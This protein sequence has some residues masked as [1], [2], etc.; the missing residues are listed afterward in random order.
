MAEKLIE[1]R[2]RFRGYQPVKT[3]ESSE[4]EDEDYDD[5]RMRL[6]RTRS[7]VT[8]AARGNSEK[9]V[10]STQKSFFCELESIMHFRLALTTYIRRDKSVVF[11]IDIRNC[12][13]V[14]YST[15]ARY[16]LPLSEDEECR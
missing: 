2:Q 15:H 16:R 9:A 8:V 14:S 6:T 4:D 3:E 5:R 12:I 10:R 7:D 13:P 11:F 1:L